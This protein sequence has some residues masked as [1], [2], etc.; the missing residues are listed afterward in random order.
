MQVPKFSANFKVRPWI[1]NDRQKEKQAAAERSYEVLTDI[2]A[3][4]QKPFLADQEA[5]KDMDVLYLTHPCRRDQVLI[6]GEYLS[7]ETQVVTKAE[8]VLYNR[9]RGEK[10]HDFL[11]RVV[12]RYQPEPDTQSFWLKE[13]R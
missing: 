3:G 8:N 6:S 5:S 13:K 2:V 1:D 4:D 10:I 11:R 12:Q 7:K 9:E